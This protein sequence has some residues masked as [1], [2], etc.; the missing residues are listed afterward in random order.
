VSGSPIVI[1]HP[2][3]ARYLRIDFSETV[4]GHELGVLE[5]AVF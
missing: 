4:P 3:L 2:V 5:W 1:E